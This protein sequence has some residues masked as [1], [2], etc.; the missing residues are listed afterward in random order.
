MRSRITISASITLMTLALVTACSF[1]RGN[2]QPGLSEPNDSVK[3]FNAETRFPYQAGHDRE[4]LIISNFAKLQLETTGDEVINTMG[5]PD[6]LW[7]FE[8]RFESPKGWFWEY[9]LHKS[10]RNAPD[11]RDRYISLYFDKAG[12]LRDISI[13]L[14]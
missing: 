12:K 11:D 8:R 5:K 14:K 1:F 9:Y 6:N 7:T 3:L 4:E 10:Y 13:H 2:Q